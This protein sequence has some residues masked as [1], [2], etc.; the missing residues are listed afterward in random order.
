[1]NATGNVRSKKKD[2]GWLHGKHDHLEIV[3]VPLNDV[4]MSS[5]CR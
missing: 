1:M 4:L 2:S 5:L 3:F